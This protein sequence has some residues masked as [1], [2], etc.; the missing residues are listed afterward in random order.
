MTLQNALDNIFV[1]L[2]SYQVIHI[3]TEKTK[4]SESITYSI[5]VALINAKYIFRIESD[6]YIAVQTYQLDTIEKAKNKLIWLISKY[7]LTIKS[8]V[9]VS[10]IQIFELIAFCYRDNLLTHTIETSI[11]NR[12]EILINY[13]IKSD[14][15]DYNKFTSDFNSILEQLERTNKKFD[16]AIILTQEN[17]NILVRKLKLASIDI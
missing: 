1:D 8:L 15:I 5:G 2:N 13:S 11:L 6:E 9:Y 12:K 4:G 16:I 3:V 17:P 10:N 7:S 14:R